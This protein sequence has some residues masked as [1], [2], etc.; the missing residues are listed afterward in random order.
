MSSYQTTNIQKQKEKNAN[1]VV[2]SKVDVSVLCYI[3]GKPETF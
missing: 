2:A 3:S 1:Q